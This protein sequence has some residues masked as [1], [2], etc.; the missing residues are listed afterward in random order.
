MADIFT[1][2]AK[3]RMRQ[4]AVSAPRIQRAARGRR[5]YC[6]KGIYRAEIETPEGTTVVIYKQRGGKRVI[7][8]TW[9]RERR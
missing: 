7:L 8:S 9:K 1:R 5:T 6:G 3:R 2:H 4:R